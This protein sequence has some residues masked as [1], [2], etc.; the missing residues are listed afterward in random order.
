MIRTDDGLREMNRFS[1]EPPRR[2]A[3]HLLGTAFFLAGGTA[4][5]ALGITSAL[6]LRTRFDAAMVG[7]CFLAGAGMIG[8]GLAAVRGRRL[9]VTRGV[10][11]LLLVGLVAA[12]IGGGMIYRVVGEHKPL[13]DWSEVWRHPVLTVVAGAATFLAARGRDRRRLGA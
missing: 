8:V 5:L 9:T 2:S 11:G 12:F 6:D 4:S 3:G 10:P 1:N 13:V 7:F